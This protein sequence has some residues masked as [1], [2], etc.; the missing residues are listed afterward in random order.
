MYPLHISTMEEITFNTVNLQSL[1]PKNGN[2]SRKERACPA[3]V[4][5]HSSAFKQKPSKAAFKCPSCGPSFVT[6]PAPS[7]E[8]NSYVC[9]DC[10]A[11]VV[12]VADENT[13]PTC[14][15]KIAEKP[16]S[17]AVKS[18][19]KL[20]VSPAFKALDASFTSNMSMDVDS[21]SMMYSSVLQ[22]RIGMKFNG[23]HVLAK[24]DVEKGVSIR[25]TL[26][27]VTNDSA[28]HS[29][30]IS[31]HELAEKGMLAVGS[32]ALDC[33]S[34]QWF[35]KHAH[36][37][38]NVVFGGAEAPQRDL[39]NSEESFTPKEELPQDNNMGWN[40][41]FPSDTGTPTAA[42]NNL[43]HEELISE[44]KAIKA[45]KKLREERYEQNIQDIMQNAEDIKRSEL[46]DLKE[47][48]EEE[49]MQQHDIEMKK[50][51]EQYAREITEMKVYSD[52]QVASVTSEKEKEMAEAVVAAKEAI[53]SELKTTIDEKDALLS[54]RQHSL[55]EAESKATKLTME[56]ESLATAFENDQKAAAET[57]SQN[58]LAQEIS[59]KQTFEAELE[60]LKKRFEAEK[61]DFEIKFNA[62]MKQMKE[63]FEIEKNEG[64]QSR[65]KLLR[66]EFDAEW[67]ENVA[68]FDA[69]TAAKN[70]EIK[71]LRAELER[72]SELLKQEIASNNARTSDLV[73]ANDTKHKELEEKLRSKDVI[74]ADM[75]QAFALKKNGLE[76]A[77][78]ELNNTI[79]EQQLQI[80]SKGYA[81]EEQRKKEISENKAFYV[82]EIEALCIT[83]AAEKLLYATEQVALC[84]ES[85]QAKIAEEVQ[86][87]TKAFESEKRDLV[88]MNSSL[89]KRLQEASASSNVKIIQLRED[90]ESKFQQIAHLEKENEKLASATALASIR[91]KEMANAFEEE[92]MAIECS[93]AIGKSMYAAEQ[94]DIQRKQFEG[95]MESAQYQLMNEKYEVKARAM[96]METNFNNKCATMQENIQQKEQAFAS[97]KQQIIDA[98]EEKAIKAKKEME[99][100]ISVLKEMLDSNAAIASFALEQKL[101]DVECTLKAKFESEK[102]ELVSLFAL[103]KVV[104]ATEQVE[105][106]K[107]ENKCSIDTIASTFEEEKMK[108]LD[109]AF[110]KVHE[111][112]VEMKQKMEEL[113][114]SFQTEK[115]S[116]QAENKQRVEN[117]TST[118]QKQLKEVSDK[119]K[120]AKEEASSECEKVTLLHEEEITNLKH[121]HHAQ[122]IESQESAK[123]ANKDTVAEIAALKATHESKM[124]QQ[125]NKFEAEMQIMAQCNEE[126]AEYIVTLQ[127]EIAS[128]NQE[129]SESKTAEAEYMTLA[130]GFEVEARNNQVKCGELEGGIVLKEKE[131]SSLKIEIAEKISEVSNLESAV[132]SLKTNEQEN[133]ES[134]EKE[135]STLTKKIEELQSAIITETEASK[136]KIKLV[137]SLRKKIGEINETCKTMGAENEQ[138]KTKLVEDQEQQEKFREKFKEHCVAQLDRAKQTYE[139]LKI[140]TTVLVEEI[141][142]ARASMEEK[143]N[144]LKGAV[145]DHEQ[146]LSEMAAEMNRIIEEDKNLKANLFE[147]GEK[148]TELMETNA[149]LKT[150]CSEMMVDLD[151][152]KQ[153]SDEAI[154]QL[155]EAKQELDEAKKELDEAKN[156]DE[157]L[158]KA[159]KS[160][161]ELDEAKK[162]DEE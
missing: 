52:K 2:Y 79:A 148:I 65:E 28:L 72:K 74:I 103:E 32:V 21:P 56:L 24:F 85:L 122:L 161:E 115:S 139:K 4:R 40:G 15:N 60:D 54:E 10:N 77:V 154:Q 43:K 116:I 23:Q 45:E 14:A 149:K 22:H 34:E 158:D 147:K 145:A 41:I 121:A 159:K 1:T 44:N 29:G 141:K 93:F 78:K 135:R 13:T 134:A 133:K 144:A 101:T 87:V 38:C 5:A 30:I 47:S 81:W 125:K 127:Q 26:C 6:F 119:L 157:E 75:Q 98:Y 11:Q 8:E 20:F 51:H 16:F 152:A 46:M 130:T 64:L 17:S 150:L 83:N 50:V 151:K 124:L 162:S 39:A 57:N 96:E 42:E 95:E 132:E 19:K 138:L 18:S 49:F 88:D 137:T 86:S 3:T 156:S 69:D 136:A 94:L 91:E 73:T 110:K 142:Q 160:D 146:K 37:I 66:A 100:E 89:T 70:E 102:E 31:V 62:Q 123:H 82:K 90:I 114:K 59:M 68:S 140:K 99:S 112:E 109:D 9:G 111:K 128:K 80:T 126:D 108:M 155:G 12:P 33:L 97:E 55:E 106:C 7:G 61:L 36:S 113:E 35:D 92:K 105:K 131:I 58:L 143:D 27:A 48:L 118:L 53:S 129:I 120:S 67:K 84:E 63:A 104:F 25:V 117:E 76:A 107:A 71:A 153:E